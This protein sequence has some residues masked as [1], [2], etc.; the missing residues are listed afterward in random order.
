MRGL[1]IH[2]RWSSLRFP[3]IRIVFQLAVMYVVF[4]IF[5]PHLVQ[6][7]REQI[8]K[9]PQLRVDS[10]NVHLK[11]NFLVLLQIEHTLFE[12]IATQGESNINFPPLFN[13]IEST[14]IG[15]A[16]SLRLSCDTYDQKSSRNKGKL[17]N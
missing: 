8:Y 2:F 3:N 13:L 12:L 16:L 6:K 15:V 7:C 4:K 5:I 11:A 17:C 14:R 9:L 10:K 1:G